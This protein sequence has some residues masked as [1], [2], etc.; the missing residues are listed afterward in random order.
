LQASPCVASVKTSRVA[1][2]DVVITDAIIYTAD[3]HRTMARALS[4]GAGK[5][6]STDFRVLDRNILALADASHVED[7]ENTKGA[8]D[9]SS[10][11]NRCTSTRID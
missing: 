10:W 5:L 1:P 9:L 2:T 4:I 11:A 3:V 7:I 8:R 6:L